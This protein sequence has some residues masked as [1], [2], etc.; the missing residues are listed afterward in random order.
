MTIHGDDTQHNLIHDP[1]NNDLLKIYNAPA[2]SP[3]RIS[4]ITRG[5]GRTHDEQRHDVVIEDNIFQQLESSDVP[6]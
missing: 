1:F 2:R 3:S 5:R 4:S 6:S